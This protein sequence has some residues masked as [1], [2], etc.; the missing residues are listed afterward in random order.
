MQS[1]TP[2]RQVATVCTVPLPLVVR[3][4]IRFLGARMRAQTQCSAMAWTLMA[5]GLLLC[6][7]CA[8]LRGSTP[9]AVWLAV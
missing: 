6:G 3:C 5:V 1:D 7:F 9:L 4:T 2:C 8:E